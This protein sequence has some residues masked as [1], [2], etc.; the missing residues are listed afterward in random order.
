VTCTTV[1]LAKGVAEAQLVA[2]CSPVEK[3]VEHVRQVAQHCPE[4]TLITDVGSTKRLI[5][6]ALDGN[7]PRGCRFLGSHP[8]AGGE[9]AGAT[10]ANGDLFNGRMV[11]LTPTKNT[12]A[13]DYDSLEHFWSALGAVVAQC[14]ADE[15][16]RVLSVTSHLPHLL[17]AAL[18]LSLSERHF[19]FSGTGLLDSTRIAAGD[20]SLWRQV[21]F[22]NRE[23]V[24]AALGRFHQQLTALRTAL[25][26]GDESALE[27]LL[28]TAKKT[29]DALGS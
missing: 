21:L 4:G 23:N 13:E 5:V 7:L 18:A 1:D 9:K 19:R 6:E 12:L 27:S 3:I 26:R 17:A 22:Q 25:D 11:V 29:R 24:L 14:P 10:H 28:A 16:D 8:L 15:H 20:P 2:V